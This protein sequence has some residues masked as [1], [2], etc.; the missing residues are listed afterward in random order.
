MVLNIGSANLI[1]ARA[2]TGEVDLQARYIRFDNYTFLKEAEDRSGYDVLLW[3]SGG[4]SAVALLPNL[5]VK[6]PVWQALNRDVRFRRALSL[7]IDR[8]EINQTAFFGLAHPSANTVLPESPLFSE[9]LRNG[10]SY[11]DYDQAN[12][13]L[14]EIG[15]TKR[16]ANGIRLLPDGRVA[17]VIVETAGESTL[18]TDVLQLIA[19]YWKKIGIKMFIKASQRDILR[20]RAISRR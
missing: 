16:D 17:N 10:W 19:D 15:L 20:S 14:D 13:L 5:N 2:G 18:E 9:E 3:K 7:A 4:G 1:P 12:K 8:D 11:T 6:D